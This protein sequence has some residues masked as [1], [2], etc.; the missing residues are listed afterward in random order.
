MWDRTCILLLS[1]TVVTLFKVSCCFDVYRMWSL[2]CRKIQLKKGTG[3]YLFTHFWGAK[4][5]WFFFSTLC[6]LKHVIPFPFQIP[7]PPMCITTYHVTILAN[8]VISPA[9][10]LPHRTF[11]KSSVNVALTVSHETKLMNPQ[12]T[13]TGLLTENSLREQEL[14]L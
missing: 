14:H 3:T 1:C 11:V 9:S 5:E 4:F 6:K 13:F 7:L 10:A 2:H 12:Q 8:L